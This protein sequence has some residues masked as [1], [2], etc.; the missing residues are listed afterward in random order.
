[1]KLIQDEALKKDVGDDYG[2]YLGTYISA[3]RSLR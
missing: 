1:M 2:K 3:R